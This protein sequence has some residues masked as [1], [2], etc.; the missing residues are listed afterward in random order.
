MSQVL[1]ISLSAEPGCGMYFYNCSFTR[2]DVYPLKRRYLKTYPDVSM[3]ARLQMVCH[4]QLQCVNL[5][6]D[7][8]LT[9]N[10]FRS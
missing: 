3:Y 2:F 5:F 6:V 7:I 8:E 1:G 10:N 4:D 9:L